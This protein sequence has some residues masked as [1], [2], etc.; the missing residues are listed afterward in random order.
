MEPAGA[1]QQALPPQAVIMQMV[2][3]GWIARAISDISRLNIS[4]ALKKN[5]PMSA[6][7]LVATGIDA[8]ADALERVMRACAS[9]GIFTEDTGGRFGPTPLSDVLTASS[10]MSVKVVAQ[11]TGGT[12]LKTWMAL[13]EGIRTG[14][15]QARQ[16]FGMEWWDYL[17]AN[18]KEM[19][20]FAEAMKSNSLNSMRGVLEKCDFTTVANRPSF[21]PSH[22][23]STKPQTQ[24]PRAAQQTR[25]AASLHD[26]SHTSSHTVPFPVTPV[27]P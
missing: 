10:P 3:G 23:C 22:Q 26:T 24:D 7:E 4:D 19:E 12:W 6:T 14:K 20:T 21:P 17:N 8:N 16:V 9:V 25:P 15:P 2:M 11:E 13:A 1:V 18:P 5:G 27:A